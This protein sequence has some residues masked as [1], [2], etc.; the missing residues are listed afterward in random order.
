[1]KS[2]RKHKRTLD[3]AHATRHAGGSVN[4]ITKSM[5]NVTLPI[6]FIFLMAEIPVVAMSYGSFSLSALYNDY[7]NDSLQLLGVCHQYVFLVLNNLILITCMVSSS[8]TIFCFLMSVH[9]RD[10]LK[11]SLRSGYDRVTQMFGR[12]SYNE[13]QTTEMVHL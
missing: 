5:A 4:R 12:R 8:Y 6:V 2:R 3:L 13:V 10:T 1:M 11:I 9:Y 7:L